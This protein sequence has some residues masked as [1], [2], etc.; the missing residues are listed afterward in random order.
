MK[1]LLS[2][3]SLCAL[4]STALAQKTQQTTSTSTTPATS[5]PI[6]SP[7]ASCPLQFGSV[8]CSSTNK[9]GELNGF[10]LVCQNLGQ[11][12][13]EDKNQC[14]CAEADKAKCQNSTAISGT[15]P[16]FGDCAT[17]HCV[18]SYGFVSNGDDLKTC[19]EELYC[20]KTVS[21]PGTPS[22]ICHTCQSCLMQNDKKGEHLV[23]VM[24][25]DCKKI[26][27][28]SVL[29]QLKTDQKDETSEESDSDSDSEKGSHK[30]KAETSAGYRRQPIGIAMLLLVG[31]LWM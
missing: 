26:C 12:D 19:A 27:P 28:E 7:R 2:F 11:Q 17:S 6:S 18:K 30:E 29:K 20:I 23:S 25:F 31:A 14:V 4:L 10:Q 1:S 8:E 5:A 22:S 15:V 9:C 3:A 13:G 24:R 21:S 16:Q